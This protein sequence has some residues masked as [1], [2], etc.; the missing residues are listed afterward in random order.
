VKKE[1]K[2]KLGEITWD[3]LG[4][5]ART[6]EALAMAFLDNNS[7]RKNLPSE[8]EFLSDRL[9]EYLRNLKK[10]GYIEIEKINGS[11]SVRLTTK[12]KIKNMENPDNNQSDGQLRILSYDIPEAE[13][14]KRQH[15]C[16]IIRRIGFKQLQKSLWICQF[17][18]A[19]EIDLVIDELQIRKY[20]AYFIANK[21]NVDEHIQGLLKNN[22]V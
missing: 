14:G 19:D 8:K 11:S 18:K 9:I 5:I 20:V 7:L 15:F 2:E 22:S 13:S 21:S 6:P 10:S 16:R 4:T 12:G 17:N 3:I 1:T